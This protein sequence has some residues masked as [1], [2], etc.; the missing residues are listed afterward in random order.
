MKLQGALK[1]DS[2]AHTSCIYCLKNSGFFLMIKDGRGN[3][4]I[5]DFFHDRGSF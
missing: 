4:E 1:T 5:S 3:V 2:R